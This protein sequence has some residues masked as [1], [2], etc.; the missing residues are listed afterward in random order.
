MTANSGFATTGA[1]TYS[2]VSDVRLLTI[3]SGFPTTFFNE[4]NFSVAGVTNPRYAV[5]TDHFPIIS[6]EV[7]GG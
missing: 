6:Y 5:Q 4:V 7:I 2:Y 1:L 3:S